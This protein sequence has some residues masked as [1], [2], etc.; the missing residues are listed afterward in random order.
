MQ[1][2]CPSCSNLLSVEEGSDCFRFVCNSCPYIHPITKKVCS[3]LPK[4]GILTLKV[5]FNFCVSSKISNRLYPK[6]KDVDEVLG[7]PGAWDNAQ[8]TD[9]T[10]FFFIYYVSKLHHW[11]FL[12]QK[13]V[14]NV[15]TVEHS[16]CNFRLEA[17]TKLQRR[18]TDAR[19]TIA[20]TDGKN[21]SFN[22][23]VLR[24]SCYARVK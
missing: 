8:I 14:Q 17:P 20:L 13:N 4:I 22:H 19:T 15:A 11:E 18:F 24:E 9:G 21:I 3:Y 12:L 10:C 1:L 6:L 7:G 23:H 2:F 16:S 5:F